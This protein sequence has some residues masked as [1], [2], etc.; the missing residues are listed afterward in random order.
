MLA[1]SLNYLNSSSKKGNSRFDAWKKR[2]RVIIN[3]LVLLSASTMPPKS[4]PK[5]TSGSPSNALVRVGPRHI[6]PRAPKLSGI[7]QSEE[8]PTTSQA[9]VLRNGKYG[10]R[11]TGEVIL[12]KKMSGREKMDLLAGKSSIAC[13]PCKC[14]N[15]TLQ[16]ILLNNPKEH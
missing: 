13:V 10:A 1:R 15:I 5:L 12:M 8:K 16:R 11:G 9:L 4:K 3:N 7:R 2:K 14:L 6:V